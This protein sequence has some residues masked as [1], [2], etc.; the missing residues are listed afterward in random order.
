MLE[1]YIRRPYQKI[2]VDPVARVL[3]RQ[4]LITPMTIT[5]LGALAGLITIPLLY[6]EEDWEN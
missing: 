5:L 1:N 6:T 4:K 2:L 3:C